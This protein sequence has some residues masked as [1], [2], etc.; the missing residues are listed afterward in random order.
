MEQVKKK[1]RSAADILQYVKRFAALLLGSLFVQIAAWAAYDF[2]ELNMFMCGI[3]VIVTALLYHGIQLEEGTGVSRKSV[4]FAAILVPFLLGVIL[5][6][7]MLTQYPDLSQIGVESGN[8]KMLNLISLYSAR[9]VING[10]V[11]L[12]FAFAD[13]FYLRGRAKNET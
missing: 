7:V 12:L 13:S 1:Q 2:M 9:L 8:E 4:F 10:A 6:I 3:S 11:L 5:T